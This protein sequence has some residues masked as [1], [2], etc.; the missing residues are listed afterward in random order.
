MTEREA[1]EKW[2][3]AQYLYED[4]ARE[5]MVRSGPNYLRYETSDQWKAWQASRQQA[6]AEAVDLCMSEGRDGKK[7]AE[8]RGSY[9]MCADAIRSLTPTPTKG[10]TP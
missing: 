4:T 6:L 7:K 5:Q 2:F 10:P 8:I 9:F 1:F 3:I